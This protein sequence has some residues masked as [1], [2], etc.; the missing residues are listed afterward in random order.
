VIARL[1]GA[2]KKAVRTELFQKRSQDEGLII[3]TGA[4]EELDAYV[5]AEIERWKKIVSENKITAE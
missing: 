3:S 2:I 1:N 4:P 5:R